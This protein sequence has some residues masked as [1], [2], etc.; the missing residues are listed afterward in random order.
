MSVHELRTFFHYVITL[1]LLSL[2]RNAT[3]KSDA[4]CAMSSRPLRWLLLQRSLKKLYYN[5]DER[6][7]EL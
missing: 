6:I 3:G 7:R 1:S 5:Y 2:E 4:P